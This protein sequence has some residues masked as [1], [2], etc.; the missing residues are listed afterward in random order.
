MSKPI[1]LAWAADIYDRTLAFLMQRSSRRRPHFMALAFE[2][3]KIAPLP[4]D[5]WDV[6]LDAIVTEE[7]IYAVT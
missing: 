4:A 1:A 6:R 5:A 7:R 3:Q 2:M